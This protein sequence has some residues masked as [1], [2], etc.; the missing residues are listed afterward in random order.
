MQSR[1]CRIGRLQVPVCHRGHLSSEA[2]VVRQSATA[3]HEPEPKGGAITSR[4]AMSG[5]RR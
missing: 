4:L 1:R 5:S 3:Y 2:I